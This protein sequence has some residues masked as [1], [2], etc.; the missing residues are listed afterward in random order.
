[1]KKRSVTL[2]GHPT[3][4]T[5][6]DEFWDVLK[7]IANQQSLSIA[8]L[9]NHIDEDRLKTNTSG[10]SSAIRI[11]VLKWAMKICYPEE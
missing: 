7:Q 10:L 4:I 8:E 6:E 5:L 2:K 3:S 1:M 9:I 11:Y